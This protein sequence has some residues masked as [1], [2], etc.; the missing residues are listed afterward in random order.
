MTPP[1]SFAWDDWYGR[2]VRTRHPEDYEEYVQGADIVSFDIYPVTHDRP[3]VSSNLWY[4]ARGVERLVKWTGG[5]KPVYRLACGTANLG[6]SPST[7]AMLHRAAIPAP[8]C[9]SR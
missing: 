1:P 9:D 8:R 2:G 6:R 7:R 5:R 3:A 4:V